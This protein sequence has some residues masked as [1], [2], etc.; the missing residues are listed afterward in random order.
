MKQ[1]EREG[2]KSRLRRKRKYIIDERTNM[3]VEEFRKRCCSN[4][5]ER[6]RREVKG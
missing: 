1:R 2:R 6:K 5:S 3:S 4:R